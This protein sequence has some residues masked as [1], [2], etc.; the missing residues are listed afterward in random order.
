MLRIAP[1]LLFVV[2]TFTSASAVPNSPY[3]PPADRGG[4]LQLVT[5]TVAP[6]HKACAKHHI[7]THRFERAGVRSLRSAHFWNC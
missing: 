5:Q 6:C 3:C 4:A 2:L 7:T 1:F